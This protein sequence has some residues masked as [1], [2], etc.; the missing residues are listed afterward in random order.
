MTTVPPRDPMRTFLTRLSLAAGIA[1]TAHAEFDLARSLGADP[2]IAVMLPVSIDAYVVAALRWFKA[3]DV[4]LS[5]ALM[6]AAQVAAHLLDARVMAVNIPMVVVVSLLVPV[7]LWR[8][9]ALARNE[10]EV[11]TPAMPYAPAKVVTSVPAV[12]D[13]MPCAWDDFTTV[14]VPTDTGMAT[15]AVPAENPRQLVTQVVTLTPADLRREASKLNRKV[16]ADTGK[17]VT[18]ENIREEL[19]LSRRAAASLWREVTGGKRS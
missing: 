6:G 5:L 12:P 15:N 2:V 1:F 8:T 19:G 9:H 3:L 10:G 13:P 16:V 18:I 17:P 4:T 14:K 11:T 7:A